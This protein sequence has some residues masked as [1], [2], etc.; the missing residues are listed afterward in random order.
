MDIKDLHFPFSS[1]TEFKY[2]SNS[3]FKIYSFIVQ[4]IDSSLE[5]AIHEKT[6]RKDDDFMY[7]IRENRVNYINYLRQ[8]K[9]KIVSLAQSLT[10]TYASIK[11][12][13]NVQSEIREANTEINNVTKK[14]T[15]CESKRN[16]LQIT[17]KTIIDLV[18]KFN[19]D[20]LEKENNYNNCIS[21]STAMNNKLEI[22]KKYDSNYSEEVEFN[23]LNK[24]TDSLCSLN[25]NITIIARLLPQYSNVIYQLKKAFFKNY[26]MKDVNEQLASNK[27][28]FIMN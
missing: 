27:F 19:E 28:L 1:L 8:I 13:E 18:T 10:N 14:I 12:D 9:E 5:I 25:S 23:Y 15:S 16:S 24:E 20:K 17:N 4:S 21:D 26:E 2:S 22:Y 7:Y 6:S 3:R 11:N